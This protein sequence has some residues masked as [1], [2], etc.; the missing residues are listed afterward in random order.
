MGLKNKRAGPW[1]SKDKLYIAEHHK[2]KSAAEIADAIGKNTAK[3]E[4]YILLNFASSFQEISKSAEYDITYS[5]IWHDIVRQF[6][7]DERKMFLHHWGRIISQFKDDVY[8]TEQMQVVDTIKL[9]ILMN[10]CLTE[11]H[12]CMT[13]IRYN[14]RLLDEE[15]RKEKPDRDK[16]YMFNLE[17]Q[18]G[19]MR[20]AQESLHGDYENLLQEKNKILKEMKAT[21]DAR[22]KS[23]ESYKHSFSGWMVRLLEDKELR[24]KVGEDME[25][26]RIAAGFEHKRLSEYHTYIDGTLDRPILI[27]EDV[28]RED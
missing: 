28:E 27:P 1:S 23:I 15:R 25:K 20:A 24:K 22:I 4:E 5:P 2:T 17:K 19:V 13:E 16:D 21:R 14:E 3:V 8:P 11:Q 10:R 6:T 26:M 9:D 7:A 12:R 18:I